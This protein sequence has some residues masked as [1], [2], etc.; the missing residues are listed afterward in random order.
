M[1]YHSEQHWLFS[2]NLFFSPILL[3]F[4]F[5]FIH[6]L[7]HFINYPEICMLI[8]K[9]KKTVNYLEKRNNINN[10]TNTHIEEKQ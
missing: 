4:F 8:N 2:S 10:N 7:E 6:F 3:F 9:R 5:S 1:Q